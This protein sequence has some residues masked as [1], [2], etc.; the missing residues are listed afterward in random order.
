[1]AIDQRPLVES[2]RA[3]LATLHGCAQVEL[4]ETHIS[5]VLVA[6]SFAYKL[7]K[8][9]KL[10]FLDFST[11]DKRRYYC[12]QELR[13]N[14]R[15]AP[16]LYLDV[17]PVTGSAGDPAIGGD[18]APIE[19]AV[20]MRAFAQEDL[21]S[22]VL[23][24]GAL[25]PQHIDA[26]AA[27]VATF[28]ESIA[29]AGVESPFG[30]PAVIRQEALDN[31]D[32]IGR[33][34]GA[35]GGLDRLHQW[36]ERESAVL[37][38]AF[39][40]R[41][42]GGFVRECHG[43]L[44]LDNIALVD[45]EITPFDGI[46]FNDELRWIDVM[47]EIAFLLMDLRY[48][49]R[50]DLSARFLNAWLEHTGDYPGLAVLR[51]YVVYRALVRAKVAFLRAAQGHL[52]AS[53][54]AALRGDHARHLALAHSHL[55]P[56]RPAIVITHGFSGC[57]KT[58]LS[59]GMLEAVG[60]VRIRSDIERKRLAGLPATAR[61][62]SAIAGGLYREDM[63]EQTYGHLLAG[64]E[65]IIA[66]GAIAIVDATFLQRRQRELFRQ[67][68]RQRGVPFA[69]VSFIAAE[70]ELRA[71]IAARQSQG[72]G[73]SEA[74]LAVL[75]HQL[76]TAEALAPDELPHEIRFET[77]GLLPIAWD[78]KTWRPLMDRLGTQ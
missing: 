75:E 64:A 32:E 54:R 35:T 74:D 69:I 76:V 7:K 71:R 28:H 45:G 56:Q 18:G 11:L 13:L 58:T 49:G 47:N 34:P 6:G 52:D 14:R 63:N 10:P 41:R 19:Y 55:E 46:E 31:I 33:L 68:A 67:L 60:A 42:V 43:D 73:A 5:F 70:A 15:Y 25:S 72:D 16:Q 78:R 77:A 26:L 9:V 57:G 3:Y 24:R 27:R 48:R 66:A 59:Q 39:L 17:V 1:M 8:A 62:G 61:S 36:T 20:R 44:H 2:L 30:T 50:P 21:A 51:Y 40:H 65:A 22:R 23:L 37:A 29:R 12:E 53:A 38:G 4:L